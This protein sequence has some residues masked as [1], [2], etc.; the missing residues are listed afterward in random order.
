MK[1][2]IFS[3]LAIL[4][5][6]LLP[7]MAFEGFYSISK[8]RK[9]HL[10]ML[11]QLSALAGLTG[12]AKSDTAAAYRPYFS[13]PNELTDLI[14]LLKQDGVG[15]GN[16][17]FDV[18]TS[19]AAINTTVNGCPSIKPNLR[20]EAFF[21]RSSA[22]NPFES[23]TAFYDA[24][25]KLDPRLAAFFE[26][27][28][29]PHI[30]MSSNA[31]GERLTVPD[32]AAERI[33]L[34]AGDSVAYGAMIDD[35]DTI[36]SQMQARDST[37]RYVNLGVAGIDAEAIVCRLEDAARRYKGRI[38]ELIY[39]Y[40]ENDMKPA[41]PYGTPKDAMAWIKAY[42]EREKIGKVTVVFSPYIYM[43]APELTR[44]EGFFGS[45]YPKREAERAE[46]KGLVEAAGYRW[47]D[48][49]SLAREEEDRQKTQ[50]AVLSLFVDHNHLS[51]LGTRRLVDRLT[52]V[53]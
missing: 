14:P 12:N 7:I 44:I 41:R 49:G 23:L 35:A 38:D 33:V 20:K 4:L 1:K 36:A 22:F 32:V 48:I 3:V 42:A 50:F 52:G 21:L 6:V 25:K 31:E 15:I 18:R 45:T 53:D 2:V 37:R 29:G 39:V 13:D 8:W 27:Y 19:D 26:R 34:V 10:S 47:E 30:I 43:V 16:S 46:L 28:G 17:P 24:G 5:F 40:C 11:Y 9:P 51:A